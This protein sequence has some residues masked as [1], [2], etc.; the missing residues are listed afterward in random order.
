MT[1][2]GSALEPET[3]LVV[4]DEDAVRRTFVEWL[5]GAGLGCRVI[6]ARDAA[7]ALRMA[8]QHGVDLAILDW[9]LGAGDNGLQL[10]QDLALFNPDVVA[11]LVTGYAHRAT[12]LEALRM[13]VRDY[14][15]KAVDLD[16]ER[17]LQSVRKQVA[18]LRPV[19]RE[20]Q[21]AQRLHAF[22]EAVEKLLPTVRTAA[23]LSEPVPFTEAVRAGLVHLRDLAGADS[24]RLIV[25]TR[26][27]DGLSETVRMYDETGASQ[28][29]T[30]PFARTL[31]SAIL[32]Q[33]EVCYT[34]LPLPDVALLPFESQ[35]AYSIGVPLVQLATLQAVAELVGRPVE[36]QGDRAQA[37]PA[38]RSAAP[39]VADLLKQ[40]LA[41]RDAQRMLLDALEAALAAGQAVLAP[42]GTPGDTEPSASQTIPHP[43][44]GSAEWQA[45]LARLKQSLHETPLAEAATEEV[46][47]AAQ[48]LQALARNYG[49]SALRFA[50]GLLRELMRLLDETAGTEGSR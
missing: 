20:R 13:G 41:Q 30:V 50:V 9:N 16:R 10:L 17:F 1:D 39:L 43:T 36:G 2:G 18:R 47:E 44:D 29:V 23:A 5:E 34:R 37:L 6:G 48:A 12:P 3:I 7:E 14:F 45:A 21:W 46:L 24:A 8:H 49:P 35:A 26:S 33:G 22:R 4:D 25:R 32:G 28:R 42:G 40:A 15:D 11:I 31:A 38:V 19:R 27:A